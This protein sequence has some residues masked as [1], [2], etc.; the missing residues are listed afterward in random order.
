[1]TYPYSPTSKY[2]PEMN[3]VNS[4]FIMTREYQQH[5][6]A[7]ESENFTLRM[8]LDNLQARL[9][10]F[11]KS[12]NEPDGRRISDVPGHHN[13]DDYINFNNQLELALKEEERL[14]GADHP[15]ATLDM[16]T[17]NAQVETLQSKVDELE[18]KN[19]DLQNSNFDLENKIRELEDNNA[20]NEKTIQQLQFENDEF[21]EANQNNQN[22][23]DELQK[24]LQDALDELDQEKENSKA[25][26]LQIAELEK[27]EPSIGFSSIEET[28]KNYD[29]VL[30]ENDDLKKENSNLQAKNDE[31]NDQINNLKQKVLDLENELESIL[32]AFDV[33]DSGDLISKYETL[34][35][36]N[37]ELQEQIDEIGQENEKLRNELDE[38]F[39]KMKSQPRKSPRDD[40]FDVT[41]I[42]RFNST[43]TID[44]GDKFS[45]DNNIISP[46]RSTT[47]SAQKKIDQLKAEN[48]KLK[49]EVE[50]L[51][52]QLKQLV[53]TK[54]TIQTSP[55]K[56]EIS[57]QTNVVKG[58]SP[59]RGDNS[60]QKKVTKNTSPIKS[61]KRIAQPTSPI[62]PNFHFSQPISTDY[63]AQLNDSNTPQSPKRSFINDLQNKINELTKQN[64]ALEEEN[65]DLHDQ[66]R[67]QNGD[68]LVSDPE[69]Q[70]KNSKNSKLSQISGLN[71][72]SS[73]RNSTLNS[74]SASSI[75][76][77]G[78]QKL[79][80]E[81]EKLRQS[82][83]EVKKTQ[84]GSPQRNREIDRLNREIDLLKKENEELRKESDMDT[85]ALRLKMELINA[86][87]RI[88]Q[89][90]AALK[91]IKINVQKQMNQ[92]LTKMTNF[93]QIVNNKIDSQMNSTKNIQDLIPRILMDKSHFPLTNLRKDVVAFID[94]TSDMMR[95]LRD[96]ATACIRATAGLL[97]K[98][99][100][101]NLQIP[102]SGGEKNQ[103]MNLKKKYNLDASFQND[104]DGNNF[105]KFGSNSPGNSAK[106]NTH[107]PSYSTK[108][109]S[110]KRL[111]DTYSSGSDTKSKKTSNASS[112]NSGNGGFNYK[113]TVTINNGYDN[114]NNDN[115]N[116]SNNSS[117]RS[118][119]DNYYNLP[120]SKKDIR[121]EHKIV[122]IKSSSMSDSSQSGESSVQK[123]YSFIINQFQLLINALWELFGESDKRAPSILELI[124]NITQFKE[125]IQRFIQTIKK[126][127]EIIRKYDD[128]TIETI[129]P[130]VVNLIK[131]VREQ[132]S[133][134]SQRLHDEHNVLI[135]RIENEIARTYYT[136]NNADDL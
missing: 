23:L 24:Q 99:N 70:L 12:Q 69:S 81:N 2:D 72:S 134:A 128:G 18:A 132:V 29:N 10:F 48:Q 89:L 21:Q 31:L 130:I 67:N 56:G 17:L 83:E 71:N 82:L 9:E 16:T 78:E 58:T 5:V 55:F 54:S 19:K 95:D 93:T 86:K 28:V 62:K 84:I 47:L 105:Y 79:K 104:N 46:K 100:K 111:I 118:A 27:R 102:L 3:T 74:M 112:G 43:F 94:E 90:E 76:S 131:S 25:K 101:K 60:P 33:S 124:K 59:I 136:N 113:R 125:F 40:T 49:E 44:E 1:M 38:N 108:D 45:L 30:R 65:L 126:K 88:S 57:T 39:E 35:Q 87:Q 68:L 80:A 36:I 50:E 119:I 75:L 85:K 117:F 92:F 121:S 73:I 91:Q 133:V 26:D 97:R 61:Q 11:I 129:S 34:N 98:G 103:I 13:I 114:N 106:S 120:K 15:E 20:E 107:S 51:N 14:D 6:D 22:Q 77:P 42:S 122:Q 116:N 32:A 41:P 63:Q 115:D 4:P 96:G 109:S 123:K 64:K 52:L 8:L 110:S 7:L 66:L 53:T 127:Y 37:N 135:E